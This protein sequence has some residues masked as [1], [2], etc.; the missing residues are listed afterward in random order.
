MLDADNC[1]S[2][3]IIEL[4]IEQEIGGSFRRRVNRVRASVAYWTATC[5]IDPTAWRLYR[6]EAELRVHQFVARW[7]PAKAICHPPR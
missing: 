1:N 5:S 4:T 2:K 7:T 3:C 6:S